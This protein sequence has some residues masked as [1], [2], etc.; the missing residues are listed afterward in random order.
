MPWKTERGWSKETMNASWWSST[1]KR[2]CRAWSSQSRGSAR[3][4]AGRPSSRGPRRALTPWTQ[5]S[6]MRSEG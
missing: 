6:M 5:R 2:N 4:T 1:A 3:R